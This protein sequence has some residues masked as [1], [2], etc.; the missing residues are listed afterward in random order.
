MSCRRHGLKVLAA[1]CWVRCGANVMLP[2]ARA[3]EYSYAL[4]ATTAGVVCVL[5]L[6]LQLLP[7]ELEEASSR[8]GLIVLAAQ[9]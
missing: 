2:S 6:F 3:S 5:C 9:W 8:H 1:Q 7:P 4:V